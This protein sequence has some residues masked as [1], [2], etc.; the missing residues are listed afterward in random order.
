MR[1]NSLAD[2][3]YVRDTFSFVPPG[4]LDRA[5]RFGLG[6]ALVAGNIV[7]HPTLLQF[8]KRV[9]LEGGAD[10]STDWAKPRT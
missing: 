3:G 9:A 10:V 2:L 6:Q 4:L 8:G 1:M 5:S 7:S